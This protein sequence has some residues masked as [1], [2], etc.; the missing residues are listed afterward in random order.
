MNSRERLI[1]ARNAAMDKIRAG[2]MNDPVFENALKLA[3]QDRKVE[4]FGGDYFETI[5]PKSKK[6]DG[7]WQSS[8]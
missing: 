1:Q 5:L 2:E 8:F 4:E 7:Y 3:G 6:R